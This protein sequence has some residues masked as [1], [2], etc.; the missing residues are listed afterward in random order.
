MK[1][2]QFISK[3]KFPC[4]LGVALRIG[5]SLWLGVIW[6]VVDKYFPLTSK[7]LW[8]NY[9]N[10]T[11]SASL[12]SRSI[13]DVWLR[14]DAVH[15]MNIAAFGYKGVG[16]GDTVFF[17][18]YPY[19]V[20]GLAKLTTINV[21]LMG[22]LVSTIATIIALICFYD[23]VLILFKD[24]NLAKRST[25]LLGLY[26][27]AFFLFA[28]FTDALFLLLAIASILMMVKKSPILAGVFACFAGLTRPQGILL[29]LPMMV[30][31][32]Q[33]LL[34][35]K[36]YFNWREI[37]ALIIAPLGFCGY[38]IWR[39]TIGLAG[40][41]QSLRDYSNV[42]FQDPITTIIKAVIFI[43]QKPTYIQVT[44]L[45]SVLFFL[46]ILVWMFTRPE[47][48]QHIAIMLYSAATWLLIATKT[49]II[50]TPLQSSNRYVLQIFFA[51]VGMTFL[52]NKL[53]KKM[54]N[55]VPTI[56]LFLSLVSSMLFALWVFI[57]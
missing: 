8:E 54:I 20:G 35:D 46:V 32:F 15:Y 13:I 6:L 28:P 49:T 26:P 41:F 29:I 45:I 10:L 21:T 39:N 27:T 2:S 14:W 56:L 23:L 1:F 51:F 55:F 9:F 25:L 40:I 24:E 43:I 19:L 16:A 50:G 30:L 22:I 31:Y 4:L 42:K 33:T 38:S 34:V 53:P 12:I 47:F 52:V 48:R 11:R 37:L 44:E 36:K 5:Y 7:A 57:G 3:Y 17:P 18:F